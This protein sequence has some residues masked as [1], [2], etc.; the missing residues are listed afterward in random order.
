MLLYMQIHI[1]Q[2]FLL[3]TNPSLSFDKWVD[4]VYIIQKFSCI[5]VGILP[6]LEQTKYGDVFV[7][8]FEILTLKDHIR[9][10]L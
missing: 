8:R 7:S 1:F 6:L 3:R 5:F 9:S 2:E 4:P 10:I